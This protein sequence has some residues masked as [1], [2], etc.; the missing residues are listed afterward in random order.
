[1]GAETTL[2][3]DTG[4]S[5]SAQNIKQGDLIRVGKNSRGDVNEVQLL[6]RYGSP[7]FEKVVPAADFN[8]ND[9]YWMGFAY[10]NLGG[11]VKIGTSTWESY[12]TVGDLRSVSV[13]IY[14]PELENEK[15]YSGSY[16]DIKSY[17]QSGERGDRVIIRTNHG[18]V[19]CAV[20]YKGEQ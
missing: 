14:N 16:E 10:E 18:Q 12:D 13:M 5:F 19:K 4:F 8:S 15:V 6:Y 7:S 17:K 9:Q 11:A 2:N 3:A 1:M 20:V